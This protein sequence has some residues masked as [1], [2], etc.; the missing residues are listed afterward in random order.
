MKYDKIMAGGNLEDIARRLT[1]CNALVDAL[2]ETVGVSAISEE[3]LSG[4]SDLL[5]CIRRDFQA[6]IDSAEDYIEEERAET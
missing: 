6:D 4:I 5:E 3:A 2:R 1:G